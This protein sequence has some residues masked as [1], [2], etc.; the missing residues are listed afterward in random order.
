MSQRWLGATYHWSHPDERAKLEVPRGLWGFGA[1]GSG[2]HFWGD[3]FG[4][5]LEFVDVALFSQ[6]KM[7]YIW[8]RV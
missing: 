5:Y 8:V 1:F 3:L 2:V 4:C 7:S 6:G